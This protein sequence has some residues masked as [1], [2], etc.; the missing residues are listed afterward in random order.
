M[1]SSVR[2]EVHWF[3]EAQRFSV[4]TA[5]GEKMPCGFTLGRLQPNLVIRCFEKS[6]QTL[7][8]HVHHV[9]AC[10]CTAA[11]RGPHSPPAQPV[12]VLGSCTRGPAHKHIHHKEEADKSRQHKVTSNF[13]NLF[14]KKMFLCVTSVL[15]LL[16][17]I[18]NAHLWYNKLTLQ[19]SILP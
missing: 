15:L 13:L 7:P 6:R 17:R 16:K 19:R 3:R 12:G 5:A 8:V 2:V 4:Y 9:P 10:A 14:S 11:W 1:K 18:S